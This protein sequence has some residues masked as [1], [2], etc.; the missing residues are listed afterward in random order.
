MT[1]EKMN[2]PKLKK[3]LSDDI[4][5]RVSGGSGWI[6]NGPYYACQLINISDSVF[7]NHFNE[8]DNCTCQQYLAK[9][10]NTTKSCKTCKNMLTDNS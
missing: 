5:E 10:E 1:E 9:K 2:Q 3:E 6:G 8:G 7:Y 4:M